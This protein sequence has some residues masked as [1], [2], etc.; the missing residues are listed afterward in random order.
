MFFDA[1]ELSSAC[2]YSSSFYMGC[3]LESVQQLLTQSRCISAKGEHMKYTFFQRF[4][5]YPK[6]KRSHTT[7]PY[8]CFITS[9]IDIFCPRT[10]VGE[11]K[12]QAFMFCGF[13]YHCI[14]HKEG[15]VNNR[16]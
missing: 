15:M 4:S 10:V 3:F 11:N 13:I 6:F 16:I 12:N 8:P 2:Y 5:A 1:A 9:A 14:I 7:E